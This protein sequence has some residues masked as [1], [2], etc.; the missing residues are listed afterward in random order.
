[1][2]SVLDEFDAF[3]SEA[4]EHALRVFVT[5]G[6]IRPYRF[7]ALVEGVLSS[8]VATDSTVW[9]LGVTSRAGLPGKVFEQ[10][11]SAAF[12]E[13]VAEADVVVT[14]AGVGSILALL[15]AGKFPIVVARRRAR[16]EHVDDHQLQAAALIERT[17]VGVVAEPH[18]VTPGLV[19]HAARMRV[20]AR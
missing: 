7:D 4:P 11:S 1:M 13:A 9:Q 18:E 15:N 10:M 12:D 2:P 3:A 8:G 19:E 5:L 16:G 14:H 17:G 6:T 20:L